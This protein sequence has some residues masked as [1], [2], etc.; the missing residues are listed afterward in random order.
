MLLSRIQVDPQCYQRRDTPYSTKTVEAMVSEGIILAKFDPLPLIR[1]RGRHVVGGDG[2]SRYEAIRRLAEKGRLPAGWK[3][4]GDWEIPHRIVDEDE[5]REL[6]WTANLSRDDFSPP[7]EARVFS[8]MLEAGIPIGEVARRAHHS[9]S[10]VQRA[11]PLNCLCRD[12]RAA[13]GKPADAGGMDKYTAFTLAERFERYRITP[14]QQQ[15]LYHNVLKH[16]SLTPKFVRALLD[17]IGQGA[18]KK[19]KTGVLFAMPA[20]MTN[21]VQQFKDR[22]KQLKRAQFGIEY[23]VVCCPSGVLDDYPELKRFVQKHGQRMIDE[24]KSR[25]D[26][27]GG[28]LGELC[29]AA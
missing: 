6:S 24:I 8:E 12:V 11:L 7:E 9:V 29:I 25:T 18:T 4:K 16:V 17:R 13:V 2:H 14:Q 10:Y 22:A 28:V 3:R 26:A 15:E 19:Q 20:S 27:D 1:R 23:L 5:A 21:A